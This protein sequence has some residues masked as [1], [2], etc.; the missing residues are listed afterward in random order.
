LDGAGHQ[1]GRRFLK[2]AFGKEVRQYPAPDGFKE[3]RNWEGVPTWALYDERDGLVR[4]PNGETVTIAPG[5]AIAINPDGSVEV[6]PDDWSQYVFEQRHDAVG[7]VADDKSDEET[8]EV[9][10]DSADD[11][12]ETR[13]LARLAEI[14]AA[15]E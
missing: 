12:E 13:L 9:V 1:I 4:Q 3:I 6:L 2:D 11:D 10:P 15:K 14:R 7:A 8:G 5:Q